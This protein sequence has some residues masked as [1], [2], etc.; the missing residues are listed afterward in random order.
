MENKCAIDV[1]RL[2]AMT[3]EKRGRP[4]R[5]ALALKSETGREDGE[6]EKLYA[7]TVGCGGMRQRFD[8]EMGRFRSKVCDQKCISRTQRWDKDDVISAPDLDE[9]ARKALTFI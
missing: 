6:G 2:W 4:R 9:E 3:K 5:W 7:V 1:F 8:G